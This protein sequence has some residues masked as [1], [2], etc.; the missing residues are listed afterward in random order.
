APVALAQWSRW[1]A[2]M[3]SSRLRPP[4]AMRTQ[5]ALMAQ[6]WKFPAGACDR[7]V[8]ANEAEGRDFGPS[9][10]CPGRKPRD[11]ESARYRLRLRS[12]SVC[13]PDT[14]SSAGAE[15]EVLRGPSLR[16]SCDRE[17]G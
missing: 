14:L 9:D 6:E 7:F 13:H 2:M 3:P 16:S 12:A 15:M 17:I 10:G 8:I 11:I 4:F 5:L 1:R